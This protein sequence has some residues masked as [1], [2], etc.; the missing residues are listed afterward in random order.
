MVVSRARRCRDRSAGRPFS[1]PPRHRWVDAAGRW[2]RWR[3]TLGR[4]WSNVATNDP[5]LCHLW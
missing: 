3:L 4:N 1:E 5:D 2:R